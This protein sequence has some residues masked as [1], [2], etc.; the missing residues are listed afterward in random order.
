[1]GP[2]SLACRTLRRSPLVST[3]AILS[4]VLG[5]GVSATMFTLLSSLVLRPLPVQD[6]RRLALLSTGASFAARQQYS[7]T[8]FEE[9]RRQ[10][11]FIEGAVAYTSCC[12]QAV[13]G[14]SGETRLL[15]R[16][17]VSGDFFLTLGV[18]ASR[19]RLLMPADDKAGAP[20]RVAV[21]SYRLWQQQF[22]G[23]DAAIGS[24]IVLDR[25]PLT[26]V[27]V[28]PPD[29]TGLEVGRAFDIVVPIRL[30][31]VLSRTP[32]D[33]DT[34]WLNVVVRLKP[35]YSHE[36][37]TSAL[38]GIQ[39]GLSRAAMPKNTRLKA[40]LTE[41]LTLEPFATGSSALR[42]RFTRPLEAMSVVA[43]LV[44]FIAASNVG[45]LLLVRAA[46][47]RH[48]MAIQTA[49]GAPRRALV[50]QI[51]AEAGVLSVAGALGGSLLALV[52][53]PAI[54]DLL[55]TTR[56]AIVLDVQLDW[57]LLAFAVAV[58]VTTALLCAVAPAMKAT[59]VDHL[60]LMNEGSRGG[61]GPGSARISDAA[62]VTQVALSLVL[63]VA[64]SLFVQT[65]QR[66]SRA[67]VGFEPNGVMVAT[68][69]ASAVPSEQRASFVEKA[70]KAVS[71]M[72]GVAAA[73]A[74]LNPPLIGELSADFVVSPPGTAPPPTAPRISRVD[75]ITP[76]WMA[77]YGVPIIEGRDFTEQ[78]QAGSP[79]V[80]LVNQA[81]V[82]L[83]S[84]GQRVVGTSLAI[85]IRSLAGD[86]AWGTRT[87]VG[88]VG[89]TAHR[90]VRDVGRPAMFIPLAQFRGPLPQTTGYVGIKTVGA[91]MTVIRPVGEALKTLDTNV[92]VTFQPIEQQIDD[93]LSED[94][95][96]ARLASG[97]AALGLVLSSLGLYGVT[98]YTAA[99]R[100]RE[101][102]I[103]L[104]LGA[105]GVSIISR[106]LRRVGVLVAVG[107]LIGV[108]VSVASATLVDGLLFEIDGRDPKT[109]ALS[110]AVLVAVAA[111]AGALPA[112]RAS[113]IDPATVLK[114]E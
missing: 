90:S 74:S 47:R 40:F 59:R 25:T 39:P 55:S 113:K 57:R 36:L 33:D 13:L 111:G 14:A 53:A 11:D 44:L 18:Q 70:V 109:L 37:A 6:P 104:A 29:F 62:I 23:Q 108:G 93:A 63:M 22:G 12:G 17:Y 75:T 101:C 73:G 41:P 98:A 114:E 72:P 86:F 60:V 100:R 78:D 5:I 61:V 99:R 26:I 24:Q 52:A 112:Y 67:T 43:L 76:G 46:A 48:E 32:I 107:V 69:N 42:Q 49:L 71:T 83:W 84:P 87:I 110:V 82:K 88:V 30:A 8:T 106:V 102:G 4:L 79:D 68:V 81:F 96:V 94:K 65:F 97:F 19:G 10:A 85:T 80:M 56:R 92:A 50:S 105:S 77:S 1:M 2:L 27:G 28:A 51:A 64:G 21:I 7:Y 38:R 20:E 54:I 35:E 3:A 103:R 89:D 91:A 16:Q 95:L 58:T 45:N 9:L 66:L 15:N 31:A 34:S